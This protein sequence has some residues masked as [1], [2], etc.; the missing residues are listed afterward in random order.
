MVNVPPIIRRF[1]SSVILTVSLVVFVA[2]VLVFM[3]PFE[4]AE[5][6]PTSATAS[7]GPPVFEIAASE[8]AAPSTIVPPG[9]TADLGPLAQLPSSSTTIPAPFGVTVSTAPPATAP[10]GALTASATTSSTLDLKLVQEA[11]GGPAS[12]RFLLGGLGIIVAM[13]LGYLARLRRSRKFGYVVR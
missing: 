13:V 1:P 11:C 7:C 6:G 8:Y 12:R 9:T 10:L 2:S 3:M 5:V 4:V